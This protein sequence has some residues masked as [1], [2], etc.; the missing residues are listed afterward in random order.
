VTGQLSSFAPH[1]KIIHADVDPAEIGKNRAVD[2]PIVGDAKDVIAQLADELARQQG[3]EGP[4]DRRDWL[5][6][7]AEWKRRY[8]YSYR[9]DDD[10]PIKPQLVVERLYEATQGEAV[11]VAGVGQHQMWASQYWRFERPRTW[12]NSG[13]LG[14]MGFA[15]PAALGA[16]AG[17]PNERVIAIDG[18]G[19]FQMT[20]QELATATTENVPITVAIVNNGHLGMV[21][22]WQEL[23]YDERYSQVHLTQDVPDYAKLAEAYGAV[24]LRAESPDDVDAVIDKALSVTDRSVVI[25]FR[26]DPREMVFPMVPAGASNDDIILGP[27]GHELDPTQAPIA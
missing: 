15:V 13:G 25:D 27:N 20:A 24:G 23:F 4:P 26:C 5:A 22:Q 1:A 2:V 16:K 19:C 8:P 9:Q 6:L 10:G 3:G 21:R 17:R 14:T 11:L 7:L 18:D 12:I